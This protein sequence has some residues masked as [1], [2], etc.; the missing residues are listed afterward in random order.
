MDKPAEPAK[1]N[2]LA[3][4]KKLAK[5]SRLP[6]PAVVAITVLAAFVLIAIVQWLIGA[7]VAI[8]RF[9]LVAIVVIAVGAWAISTKNKSRH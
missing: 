6:F 2:K 8:I 7:L 5:R 4:A 1:V 9:G 3:K